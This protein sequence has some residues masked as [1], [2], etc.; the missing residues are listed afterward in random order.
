MQLN[1]L[2]HCSANAGAMG[3]NPVEV[4]AFFSGYF[5]IEIAITA[6][7]IDHLFFRNLHHHS[8]N[9]FYKNIEAEIC[10]INKPDAENESVWKSLNTAR[11]M[12]FTQPNSKHTGN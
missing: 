6:A 5:S 9:I 10:Q 12:F 8:K 1:W 7:K 3:L 11:F 4:P 2:E